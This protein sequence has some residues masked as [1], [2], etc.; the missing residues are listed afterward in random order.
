M[1]TRVDSLARNICTNNLA[2]KFKLTDEEVYEI[3]NE[4]N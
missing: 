4:K 1:G 2:E 3:S